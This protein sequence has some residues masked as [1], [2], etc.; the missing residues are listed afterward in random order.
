MLCPIVILHLSE[1]YDGMNNKTNTNFD[2]RI[3]GGRQGRVPEPTQRA[4]IRN[5][6]VTDSRHQITAFDGSRK[7]GNRIWHAATGVLCRLTGVL[8][9]QNYEPT[10]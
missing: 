4:E 10:V 2:H 9:L 8:N 3:I 5:S 7:C 6:A 1:T